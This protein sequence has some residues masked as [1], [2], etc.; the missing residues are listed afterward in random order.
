MTLGVVALLLLGQP[1][2]LSGPVITR[3]S[4][5]EPD[6]HERTRTRYEAF[7]GGRK[8]WGHGVGRK[9]AFTFDDGPHYYTTPRLL[10]H[11]DRFGVKATFFINSNRSSPWGLVSSKNFRVLQEAHRRG[12]LIGNHTHSH[13][14]LAS[15]PSAKQRQQ[16]E[17]TDRI[18]RRV[19]GVES[20][21]FRPPYG[22]MSA[23]SG[24]L[25]KKRGSTVVM[26]S[27]GSEDDKYFN[28][29]KVLNAVMQ[30]LER[31][32]GGVVLM[33]DTH[34]WT[35]ESMPPILKA[36]RIE[37]CKQLARGEEPFEV[38]GLEYFWVPRQGQKPRRSQA[39]T[40]AWLTRRAALAKLCRT[41][42]RAPLPAFIRGES[43]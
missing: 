43:S 21:L 19:T 23:Y 10:D 25:L 20:F 11:L 38:V 6:P 9:I 24:E 22:A 17:L 36:I 2:A 35:V 33:H 40:R 29:S 16:I 12:H 28:V 42:P 7:K 41:Q 4:P 13:P 18:I 32:G 31:Q 34:Y 5:P 27:V 30:K 39:N 3:A 26:W 14:Q 15:L 1:P 37:A 8:L